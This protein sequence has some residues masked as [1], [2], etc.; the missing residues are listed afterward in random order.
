MYNFLS[1]T[2]C[3]GIFRILKKGKNYNIDNKK[4][5]KPKIQDRK[6]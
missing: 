4:K 6:K 2:K 5:I 1:N 3:D